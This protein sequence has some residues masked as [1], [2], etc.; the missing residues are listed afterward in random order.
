M[1]VK[2]IFLLYFVPGVCKKKSDNVKAM[3]EIRGRMNREAIN[4]VSSRGGHYIKYPQFSPK[5]H[6]LFDP[7][8]VHLSQLGN[9]ILL[10]N[11]QGA[12]EYILNSDG[13][14]LPTQPHN[15]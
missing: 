14:G 6:T 15:N 12:L 13:V 7:D 10:N 9:D 3:N 8:G 1:F 2:H 11:I 4:L 5:P